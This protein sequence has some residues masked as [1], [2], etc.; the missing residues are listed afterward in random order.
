MPTKEDFGD[1]R[2]SLRAGQ[3][4]RQFLAAAGLASADFLA[5]TTSIRA[6]SAPPCQELYLREYEPLST[7][8][9]KIT[10]VPRARYPAIDV[11]GH[12]GFIPDDLAGTRGDQLVRLMDQL[13]IRTI[14]NLTGT[15]GFP[16]VDPQGKAARPLIVAGIEKSLKLW[17]H[18]FRGRFL[19]FT[20]IQFGQ[21][22]MESWNVS[23]AST[24]RQGD[25]VL[26]KSS[27]FTKQAVVAL[28]NDVRAGARGLKLTKELGLAFRDW[29]G[30]LIAVDDPRLDPIWEKCGELGI[31]VAMHTA[32][33]KAFFLPFNQHNERY[34]ELLLHPEWRYAEHPDL[35]SFE[36]L[37]EQRQRIFARHPRTT[38]IALHFD[39]PND[40]SRVGR[41]LDRFPNVYVEFGGRQM[42][43]GRQPYA[44]R[45]FFLKY[46]DRILFGTD[47]DH[48]KP[49]MYRNFFRWL[50]TDDDYFDHAIAPAGGRWKIYGVNLPDSA[51]RKIYNENAR[52][53]F[54]GLEG[55]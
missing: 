39:E 1:G 5:K 23:W 43:L 7:L 44:A 49:E 3:D 37:L 29:T 24:I 15:S 51:L 31:P 13:N 50:E 30:K 2:N 8:Q 40:L 33:P 55:F 41:M 19:S 20:R 17:D 18:K 4:R 46:Q 47:V 26:I 6:T 53:I 38:F 27:D 9:I 21:Y 16:G 35:P 14:V 10:E 11:H 36:T 22:V 34:E 52:R 54:R 25:P 42:E 28:E 32:D 12:L 48:W 45:A